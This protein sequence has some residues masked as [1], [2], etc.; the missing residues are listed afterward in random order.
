MSKHLPALVISPSFSVLK[1]ANYSHRQFPNLH[2]TLP[3]FMELLL[4]HPW[5][6]LPCSFILH[7]KAP[8]DGVDIHTDYKLVLSGEL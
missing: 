5:H 1:A 3:S 7:G 8:K 6:I 4:Y 2:S